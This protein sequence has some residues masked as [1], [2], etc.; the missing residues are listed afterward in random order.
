MNIFTKF[1]DFPLISRVRRNHGLEHATLHVLTER[2]PGLPM[3]GHSDFG[4]FWILGNLEIEDLA[5]AVQEALTRLNAGESQL[6]VHPTCGT[7]FA[8]GILA[9]SAAVLAMTGVGPRLR[10]KAERLPLA[11]T[12]ATAA[13]ML[14]QP[15]G[16]LLQE[17]VTTSGQPGTLQV[18]KITRQPGHR[19]QA[20]RIVTVG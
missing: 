14:A 17:Q 2:H 7:N 20:F 8:A 3:A 9:G 5:S 12:L 18:V 13:L 19:I 6:A 1:L 16:L 10:D 11:L 4:G 15:L